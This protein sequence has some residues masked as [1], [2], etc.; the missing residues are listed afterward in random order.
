MRNLHAYLL[1]F[2]RMRQKLNFLMGIHLNVRFIKFLFSFDNKLCITLKILSHVVNI[3][4]PGFQ[5][6]HNIFL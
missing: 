3:K 1:F 4:T 2:L 6:F 5:L